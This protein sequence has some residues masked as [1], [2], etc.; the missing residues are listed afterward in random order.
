MTAPGRL[1]IDLRPILLE[2]GFVVLGVVLAFAANEW[3]Q[4]AANRRDA[5]VAQTSVRS[6]LRANRGAVQE[7]LQYHVGLTDTLFTL[8]RA[9]GPDGSQRPPPPDMRVFSNG[10]VHPAQLLSTAWDAAGAT[11]AV[12]HMAYDDVLALA[13][14]YEEQRDY[15]RQADLVGGIIY[16]G[17]F[18]RGMGGMLENYANL[19][20]I[21]S[22]FVYRECQLLASYDSVLARRLEGDSATAPAA[23]PARCTQM[24]RRQ[25]TG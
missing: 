10:F 1:R 2:A 22:A 20:N 5:R 15:R 4:A 14:V 12:R 13:H 25:A 23:R 21:I 17:M 7:S 18:E 19:A 11:D 24:E 3:R 9:S 8:L 16:T 6:E